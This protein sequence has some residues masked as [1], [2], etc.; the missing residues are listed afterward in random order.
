VTISSPI[1]A[2]PSAAAFLHD[3]HDLLRRRPDP[4]GDRLEH[5]WSAA[6]PLP[7]RVLPERVGVDGVRQHS[8]QQLVAGS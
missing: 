2:S 5:A 4:L 3:L 6:R 1:V 7:G 8:G